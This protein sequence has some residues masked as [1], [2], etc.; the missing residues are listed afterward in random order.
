MNKIDCDKCEKQHAC[1]ETGAW[2]DLEEAK[3][4]M[5]LGI[6]G[7]EFHQFEKDDDF[8]SGYCVATS[9]NSGPCTFL[10]PEGLCE[11]HKIG[12]NLKPY[13]CKEFP[14][15]NGKIAYFAKELCLEYKKIRKNK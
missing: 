11:I 6:K 13:Y 10:T 9:Y 12:Y 7:G 5:S 15:E 3:K 1:C 2:V 4:I 8:P 14:Y